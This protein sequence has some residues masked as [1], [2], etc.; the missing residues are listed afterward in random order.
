MAFGLNRDRQ[1]AGYGYCAA[2]GRLGPLAAEDPR[3]QLDLLRIAGDWL[4]E[5]GVAEAN[6]YVL[7]TNPTV[8]GGMLAGGWRIDGCTFFLTTAPF[9]QFDRYV[10]GGGLLL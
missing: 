9:G 10:P 5:R 1:L 3:T 7:S 6:A 2:D 8:L 4:A